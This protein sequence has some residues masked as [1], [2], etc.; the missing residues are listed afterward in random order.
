MINTKKGALFVIFSLIFLLIII[1]FSSITV[2]GQD[3]NFSGIKQKLTAISDEEKEVLQNL[4]ALVQEI[5]VMEKE[6]KKISQ[7]IELLNNEI[8]RAEAEISNKE[9]EYDNKLD[10]LE[11]ILI[12]Y[13]RKGPGSYLETILDAEN[14]TMF[15]RRLN[16]LRDLTRGLGELLD[17]I[18]ESKKSLFSERTKLG[19][20]LVLLEDKNKQ[21]RISLDKKSQL[22]NDME[23]YLE[24]LQEERQYYEDYLTN[25]QQMWSKL[26]PLFADITKS[27]SSIIEDGNLPEDAIDMSFS[28]FGIKG[29]ISE[30]TFNSIVAQHPLLPE[31]TF[32]FE[33]D[34]VTMYL[35]EENLILLGKFIISE[36]SN[37]KFQIEEGS[38][39]GMPLESALIDELFEEGYLELNLKPLLGDS[40]LRSVEIKD[41]QI[42]LLIIP[43]L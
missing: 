32:S 39:Y 27:F 10:S 5:E 28:I 2:I 29:T 3:D 37:L 20:K 24:S 40:S 9:K 16:L 33:P 22:K 13:Q 11:E 30:E 7:E 25:I 34:K 12:S 43:K 14:L 35:P 4:F 42:E 38:F 15:L 8:E 19:E 31:M 23:S 21:L 17:S 26:K 41:G 6:G 1:A 36:N 18:D